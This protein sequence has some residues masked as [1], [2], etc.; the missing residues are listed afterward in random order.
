MVRRKSQAVTG[1]CKTGT[2]RSR[3]LSK[4]K[5]V[6]HVTFKASVRNIQRVCSIYAVWCLCGWIEQRAN[7]MCY[8]YWVKA[9]MLTEYVRN[10]SLTSSHTF[11]LQ[12]LMTCHVARFR[13]VV[14]DKPRGWERM[15]L[16]EDQTVMCQTE[17]MCMKQKQDHCCCFVNL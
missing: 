5:A 16:L 13:H 2:G 17:K 7:Q 12:H 1:L 15:N 11:I 8:V 3:S 10:L 6:R 4:S 14:K 9:W